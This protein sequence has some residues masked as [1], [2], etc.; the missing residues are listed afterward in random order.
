MSAVHM[1]L[2][3]LRSECEDKPFL[4]CCMVREDCELL[5][6]HWFC[7]CFCVHARQKK[8]QTT[9]LS[10]MA[11]DVIILLVQEVWDLWYS[12]YCQGRWNNFQSGETPPFL[13]TLNYYQSNNSDI[14]ALMNIP[15]LGDTLPHKVKMQYVH[16]RLIASYFLLPQTNPT[17]MSR[18]S[19]L[20]HN[21]RQYVLYQT[22]VNT[23]FLHKS[24]LK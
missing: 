21:Q 9:K 24:G 7:V 15:E 2:H 18:R 19:I 3:L 11:D 23:T 10:S 17:E 4:E 14:L 16:C 6:T 12:K 20:F 1:L 13:T 8:L 5:W 22:C